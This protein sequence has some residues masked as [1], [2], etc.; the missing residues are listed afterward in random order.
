MRDDGIAVALLETS[1]CDKIS[2]DVRQRIIVEPEIVVRRMLI[3]REMRQRGTGLRRAT[4]Y[5]D[6]GVRPVVGRREDGVG[7][8]HETSQ[9]GRG[10]ERPLDLVVANAAVLSVAI[11][12]IGVQIGEQRWIEEEIRRYRLKDIHGVRFGFVGSRRR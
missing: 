10:D 12:G 11:E 2:I 1:I 8:R 3:L 4:G 6:D 5:L 9:V 7:I